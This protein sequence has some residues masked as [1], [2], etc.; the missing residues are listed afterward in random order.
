MPC[1]S[2]TS[3]AAAPSPCAG[4]ASKCACVGTAGT[5]RH[6]ALHHGA[7]LF[8]RHSAILLGERDRRVGRDARGAGRERVG[9]HRDERAR[10]RRQVREVKRTDEAARAMLEAARDDDA[11]TVRVLAAKGFDVNSRNYDGRT[12]LHLAA[13]EDH[14]H[15]ISLLVGELGADPNN[16]DRWGHTPLMTAVVGKRAEAA[17]ELRKQGAQLE[18]LRPSSLL[19]DAVVNGRVDEAAA[20]I[21][22]GLDVNV[23]D[24]DGRT[25][26]HVASTLGNLHL[27]ELLL[28]KLADVSLTDRRGVCAVDD[29]IQNGWQLVALLQIGESYP[30]YPLWMPL[31]E[32]VEQLLSRRPLVGS[33][34]RPAPPPAVTPNKRVTLLTR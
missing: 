14:I 18:L 26:L 31:P 3:S 21:S 33:G 17:A 4:P 11:E 27:V 12:S 16:G 19:L 25:A 8:S 13:A 1:V 6:F 22:L 10:G 32:P 2:C 34:E 15:V 28:A 23:A 24:Y 29:A 9:G 20:L 30:P 5:R 7:R